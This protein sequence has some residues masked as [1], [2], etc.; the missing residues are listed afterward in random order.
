MW[1]EAMPTAKLRKTHRH[2]GAP[3]KPKRSVHRD[4]GWGLYWACASFWGADVKPINCGL[5]IF[6]FVRLRES[7]VAGPMVM[8]GFKSN[9]WVFFIKAHAV[10]AVLQPWSRI[11]PF[12][13]K[14]R[15]G[16]GV[17]FVPRCWRSARLIFGR[18]PA[19]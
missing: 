8:A 5:K 15:D 17:R 2:K 9:A 13:Q 1:Q 12:W 14:F 16:N 7:L 4:V 19:V 11:S 18:L 10:D 3:A 6:P